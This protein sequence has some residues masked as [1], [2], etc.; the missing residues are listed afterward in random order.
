MAG[1]RHQDQ[2]HGRGALVTEAPVLTDAAVADEFTAIVAP[3]DGAAVLDDV[4]DFLAR[5]VSFPS[6]AAHCA[7]TLWIAHAHMVGVFESTPRLALLSPE[8]GSG[9]TRVLEVAELLVPDPCPVLNA[10]PAAIFR[11]IEQSRPTLLFDEVDA[12]FGRTGKGDDSSEDLRGLLNAGHRR[13]AT[14]PRCV[15]PNHSV[16]QFPVY[17]AVAL[18]GL[19]DLPS[20]LMS[21]SVVIRMR[22][23]APGEQVEPFRR[24]LAAPI[25]TA[26][27]DRLATWATKVA[28]ACGN[29]WPD[30]PDG[31]T[32]RP[33]D[34][35]EPLLA[36]ADAAGNHWPTLARQ[37]CID[38]AKPAGET[39]RSLGIH[40]LEDLRTV[41]AED[42]ALHT[43]TILDRLH[44]L[45]EAP[46]GNLRG[47]PIDARGLS[48]L[49]TQY[50]I[51]SKDIKLDGQNLKG[52]RREDLTDAWAR[53]TPTTPG[54]DEPP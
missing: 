12:V 49:L 34:V 52:Y 29:A 53:Y 25:G 8:P 4:R 19:G 10:S 5:F 13:S 36:V 45:D 44:H 18:A 42:R 20:T 30:M 15:G 21:R 35:W 9:K 38:L 46:W 31:I 41:F 37:A 14:I 23:R 24:R 54:P 47:E 51:R 27:H 6:T 1:R 11:L 28:T 43:V 33:A 40:L 2:A 7:V 50:G 39:A 22:R 3:D 17:A 48:R 26:L 16:Q 32:D